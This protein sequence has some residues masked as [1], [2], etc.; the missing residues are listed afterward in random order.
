VIRQRTLKNTIRATGIG[1]HTGKK[2][3][4]T[5]SPAAV[6]TGIVFKR[7]DMSP[8]V[9][10]QGSALN[11]QDTVLATTIGKGDVKISTVE[12]LM[13]A[14]AGLGIDN[15][16]VEVSGCEVPILDGS[17]APFVFLIQSAGILEQGAARRFIKIKEQ[18]EVVDG[19]KV[20]RFEPYDG[21]KCKFTI[22]FDHPMFTNDVT[23]TEID[24]AHT[25]FVREISRA[26]TFGFVKDIEALRQRDLALGGS[27]DNAIVVDEYRVLN[28]DGLRYPNEF[29]KHKVLDAIGDLYLLGHSLIGSYTGVKS[30]HALNNRLVREL[31]A[32]A[33]AWEEVTFEDVVEG[34]DDSLIADVL[35]KS[36]NHAPSPV[37]AMARGGELTASLAGT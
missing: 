8:S 15:C 26:R 23:T 12:H 37:V 30:G 6:N 3:Y 22:D 11:V 13:A 2:V 10:I 34:Q 19:D 1:L 36:L 31:L 16:Q 17:A 9:S 28:E 4:L 33:N 5:L 27:L 20:A 29:V 35:G 14:F 21:F 18:V 7:T 25:S 24:F 32:N